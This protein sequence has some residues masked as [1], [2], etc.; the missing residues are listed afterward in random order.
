[1][2]SKL[3]HKMDLG[4]VYSAQPKQKNFMSK[5]GFKEVEREFVIDIDLTDYQEEK[6][7]QTNCLDPGNESF[8]ASFKVAPIPPCC[9]R[10]IAV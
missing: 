6:I 3:P 5:E 1:M 4:A 9:C 10:G 2:V 8:K 7:I